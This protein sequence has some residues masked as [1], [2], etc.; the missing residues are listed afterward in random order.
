[1]KRVACCLLL[2]VVILSQ[3]TGC[4]SK[5]EHQE[6]PAYQYIDGEGN[7]YII[8]NMQFREELHLQCGP[9]PHVEFLSLEEMIHDL[10][11][12]NLTEEELYELSRMTKDEAGRIIIPDLDALYQPKLPECDTLEK[13]LLRPGGTYCFLYEQPHVA[14]KP[15]REFKQY[16]GVCSLDQAPIVTMED[17]DEKKMYDGTAGIYNIFIYRYQMSEWM[18]YI[19]EWYDVRSEGQAK[20]SSVDIWIDNGEGVYLYITRIEFPEGYSTLQWLESFDIRPYEQ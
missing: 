8:L 4:A 16:L 10:K 11:T 17:V 15:E 18:A 6:V 2:I 13:I 12:G 9:E 7:D 1:M 20:L 3:I 5:A 14:F 19:K